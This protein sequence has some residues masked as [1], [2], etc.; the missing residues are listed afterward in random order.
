M[1]RDRCSEAVPIALTS[2]LSHALS[3]ALI[4]AARPS[5]PTGEKWHALSFALTGAARPSL[6]TGEKWEKRSFSPREKVRMRVVTM[7]SPESVK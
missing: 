7:P 5:L 6:P 2:I 4:G 3:F 1:T